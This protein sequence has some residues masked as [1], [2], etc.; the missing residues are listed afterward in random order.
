M[1]P[2]LTRTLPRLLSLIAIM[3]GLGIVLLR[4]LEKPTITPL[5]ASSVPAELAN[6]IAAVNAAF[7]LA[8]TTAG[9]APV[10][11]ADA[12]TL[13]RR[14]SLALT[15]A[16]PSLEEIRRLEALPAGADPVQAWLSIISS[17]T[18]ATPTISRS[19]SA[20]PLSGSKR[21]PFL[22]TGVGVSSPG[23]ATSSRQIVLTMNWSAN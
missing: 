8:Q 13:A 1:R 17:P 11:E 6:E 23:S 4:Y 3:V 10:P 7:A 22:S 15:G 12:L 21:A 18:A 9:V 20:G 2:F 14:L 16:P 5:T 19:V